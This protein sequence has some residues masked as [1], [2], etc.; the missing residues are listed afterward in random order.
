M[1]DTRLQMI[2][3]NQDDR[4][5]TVSIDSPRADLTDVEVQTAMNDIITKNIFNSSGGDLIGISGARIITTDIQ[6]LSV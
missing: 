1:A 2:F 3:K 4:K 5:K 6:E